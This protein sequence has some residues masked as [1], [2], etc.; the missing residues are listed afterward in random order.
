MY[1]VGV[2]HLVAGRALGRRGRPAGV[3]CQL[4]SEPNPDH[5]TPRHALTGRLVRAARAVAR[6]DATSEYQLWTVTDSVSTGLRARRSEAGDPGPQSGTSPRARCQTWPHPF[7]HAFAFRS[8]PDAT[9]IAHRTLIE[10]WWLG[11][12]ESAAE[13][14][15]AE[16]G[17]LD[18]ASCAFPS[19]GSGAAEFQAYQKSIDEAA[20]SNHT[21]TLRRGVASSSQVPFHG[22]RA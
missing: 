5:A 6:I 12:L 15:P 19:E 9:N 14:V 16:S 11:R 7:N 3:R 18:H 4:S 22:V 1:I 21:Q 10:A 8:G 2:A 13:S 17:G 20:D